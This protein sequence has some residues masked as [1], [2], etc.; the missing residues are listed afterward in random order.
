MTDSSKTVRLAY[1]D[2]IRG[3]AI[4]LVV[5]CHVASVSLGISD[6]VPSFNNIVGFIHLPLFFFLS[7]YLFFK[8]GRFNE[9]KNIH[10]LLW[11][12][13]L[14][15][16]IPATIFVILYA[17]SFNRS[18]DSILFSRFKGGYWFTYFLFIFIFLYC[19]LSWALYKLNHRQD[20]A[21]LL[22][23]LS[24]VIGFTP[25]ALDKLYPGA[26][27]SRLLQALSYQEYYFFIFFCF[28]ALF[29]SKYNLYEKIRNRRGYEAL[30]IALPF[31]LL[32]IHG[33]GLPLFDF[34]VTVLFS[35]SVVI[36]IFCVFQ[37][38]ESFF[39]ERGFG[40]FVSFV[41]RRSLDIY[42]LHFFF[43][44]DLH[45]VGKFFYET[46]NP[47][48]EFVLSFVIVAIIVSVCL[49]ISHIV[50]GNDLLAKLLFGRSDDEKL[51]RRRLEDNNLIS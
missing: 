27:D 6:D 14:Q 13:F 32:L 1:L 49:L 36:L 39:S 43:L 30:M 35:F 12:R 31:V 19:I 18:F 21:L 45:S 47:L 5:Y 33:L 50:R 37:K 29:K 41:G 16:V 51:I 11:K 44:P 10:P 20:N 23:A 26:P 4:L 40:R 7:G 24:L 46:P 9:W 38:D 2:A 48:L 25:V 22:F 3:L 42:F 28:G 15:L 34:A 8:P 17:L